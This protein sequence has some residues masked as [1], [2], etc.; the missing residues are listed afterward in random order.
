M[1]WNQYRSSSA[2]WDGYLDASASA[3]PFH[4]HLIQH[5]EGLGLEGIRTL[6]QNAEVSLLNQGITFT[7]Y[8]EE[9]DTEKILPF[10]VL[11]RI[12]TGAEWD[13]IEQG[14]EQRLRALNLFLRDI[15]REQRILRDGVV[16]TELVVNSPHFCRAAAGIEPPGGVFVHVAGIDLIQNE[17]G[18]YLVLEDNLRIPSGVS[19]VL[20]NRLV[21]S[22]VLPDLLQQCRVRG[23]DAY[24][25]RL[26]EVLRSL[27]PEEAPTVA[28]LTPGLYNSAYFEHSFLA[29]QMGVQLVEGA[30][31]VVDQDVLYMKTTRG[32][33]RVDVLYRRVDD[34]F[35][36]PVSFRA[37]SLL[38]VPGLMHAYQAGNLALANAPGTGVADDKAMYAYVPRI[39]Q[40]YLGQDPILLQV[41]TYLCREEKSLR[42]TLDHLDEL[43]VKP[44]DGSGGYG[45][46]IGP[47]ASAEALRELRDAISRAPHRFVAQPV[48]DLS[49]LP[50]LIH[51]DDA[52]SIESRHV[53][54]R[55]FSLC[56]A[57]GEI[58]T[59]PGGLTR[60][61]L[62]RG[63]LVVNSSQGGGSKD[64]WVL[65]SCSGAEDA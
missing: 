35:L 52:F 8:S 58:R 26:L 29:A 36:D 38:G 11:P 33:Q 54:L 24:P 16:P 22:R 44:V 59:L 53:D 57:G 12:V 55:P 13:H 7:L 49:V 41:P 20:E 19:Y 30:D 14:I 61:A 23:V 47:Q 48:Q 4:A 27:S 64:T 1:Q 51:H 45:V 10:D 42:F 37:D 46:T 5:L 50:T 17:R 63:S 3:R 9:K 15:Y 60:V 39:I 65:R 28:V 62:K 34:D 56:D 40:Y 32:L 6:Q 2:H 43:V 21:S 31:L 25:R 18:E